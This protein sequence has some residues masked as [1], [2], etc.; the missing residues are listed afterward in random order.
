M[1][2]G[3]SASD[4]VAAMNICITIGKALKETG[5]SKS[6]Y[7]AAVQFRTLLGT[8]IS[9]KHPVGDVTVDELAIKRVRAAH[10][11]SEVL[12]E[13]SLDVAKILPKSL[14]RRYRMNRGYIDLED[15]VEFV[16]EN[17]HEANIDLVN[18][19]KRDFPRLSKS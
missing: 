14:I 4:I 16:K 11:L 5:G 17:E 13:P 15:L 8:K 18:S 10:T 7:Q 1:S 19:L 12:L 9:R 6:Q 3:W 2:F